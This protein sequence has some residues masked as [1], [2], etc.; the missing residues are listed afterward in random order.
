MSSTR[1]YQNLVNNHHIKSY[2]WD[3]F[4]GQIQWR[5]LLFFCFLSFSEYQMNKIPA[6]HHTNLQ[7]ILRSQLY[8]KNTRIHQVQIQKSERGTILSISNNHRIPRFQTKTALNKLSIISARNCLFCVL[9][10]ILL[11]RSRVSSFV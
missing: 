1:I 4:N 8:I 11:G 10:V 9:I 7:P 3:F 5:I 6:K 2:Y